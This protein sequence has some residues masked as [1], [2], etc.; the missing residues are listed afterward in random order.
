MAVFNLGTTLLKHSRLGRSTPPIVFHRYPHGRR[1][2]PLQT[3]RDYV[4]QRTLLAPQIDKSFIT[5]RKPYHPASKDTLARWVKD[6]LHFSGI[7][8]SLCFFLQS[9]GVWCPHGTKFEVWPVEKL[10]YLCT[11]LRQ[12]YCATDSCCNSAVCR[13][14]P[15][16]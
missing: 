3:I 1:L 14:H 10:P 8:T 2:C 5:H 16:V 9:E 12:G 15:C 4:T 13:F 11:L 7:D 6:M